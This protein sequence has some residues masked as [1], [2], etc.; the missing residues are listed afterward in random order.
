MIIL[1]LITALSTAIVL[2]DSM[3]KTSNENDEV[4]KLN[5]VIKEKDKIIERNSAMY[6]ELVDKINNQTEES[7]ADSIIPPEN[8]TEDDNDPSIGFFP[9]VCI[10]KSID[11]NESVDKLQDVEDEELSS[12]ITEVY[13]AN[14]LLCTAYQIMDFDDIDIF[15]NRL[16]IS[17]DKLLK[18]KVKG[19]VKKEKNELFTKIENL[20]AFV[21]KLN[22]DNSLS[23]MIAPVIHKESSPDNIEEEDGYDDEEDIEF[24]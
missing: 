17:K 20:I 21:D 4:E 2:K 3:K 22:T 11:V 8:T 14:A 23:K 1:T 7:N 10:E 12:V 24:Y 18:I 9:S 6:N 19:G 15:K 16:S 13:N 5:N